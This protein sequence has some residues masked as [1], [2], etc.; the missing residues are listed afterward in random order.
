MY[1]RRGLCIMPSICT[2]L[3]M[4]HLIPYNTLSAWLVTKQGKSL[5]YNKETLIVNLRGG[6]KRM[7]C[8]ILLQQEGSSSLW[9][10]VQER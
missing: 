6:S 3:D 9:V 5:C 2:M 1:G 8:E 7:H 10:F 4:K